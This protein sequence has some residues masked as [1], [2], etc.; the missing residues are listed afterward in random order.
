MRCKIGFRKGRDGK[1]HKKKNIKSSP[2]R[3]RLRGGDDGIDANDNPFSVNL[4]ADG[5]IR[6]E[7]QKIPRADGVN[8]RINKISELIRNYQAQH[9]IRIGYLPPLQLRPFNFFDEIPVNLRPV[10][11]SIVLINFANVEQAQMYGEDLKNLIYNIISEG[12]YED[13]M[14][15][16]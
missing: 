7:F 4:F 2:R 14:D 1:C 12:E 9:N 5:S 16:N 3:R 8:F 10:E 11:K 13:I 15:E 6:A